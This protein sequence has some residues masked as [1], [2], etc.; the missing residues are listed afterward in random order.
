M[1]HPFLTPPHPQ[2]EL[3]KSAHAKLERVDAAF[4]ARGMALAS[5]ARAQAAALAEQ[6]ESSA[7][8]RLA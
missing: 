6:E 8:R 1:R 5:D 7:T 3:L 4:D 2:L